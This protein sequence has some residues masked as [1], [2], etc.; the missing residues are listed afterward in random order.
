MR[1]TDIWKYIRHS[2]ARAWLAGM[3]TWFPGGIVA[4]AIGVFAISYARSH[5]TPYTVSVRGYHRSDGIYVD[6]H[7]RRPPRSV[8]H[9]KPYEALLLLSF[10]ILLGGLCS[11]VIPLYRFAKLSDWDLLPAAEYESLFPKMPARVRVPDNLAEARRDWLCARC[12][13]VI[14]HGEPYY[15]HAASNRRSRVRF[16]TRCKLRIEGEHRSYPEELSVYHAELRREEADRRRAVV[17]QYE[18]YYGFMPSNETNIPL[19]R[20]VRK[21]PVGRM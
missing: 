1:G 4:D 11:T 13:N 21:M 9:D 6:P 16:C 19:H 2:L 17:G 20:A 3:F 12:R 10:P 5:L 15:Y 8:E 18:R 7:K 14:H